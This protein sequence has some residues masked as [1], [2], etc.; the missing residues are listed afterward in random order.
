VTEEPTK[1]SIQAEF[2]GWYVSRGSDDRWHAR[3][4]GRASGHGR[5]R[6]PRRPARGDHPQ[7]AKLDEQAWL[8]QQ[9]RGQR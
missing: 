5:R 8:A 4:R 2:P 3:L 1:E 7:I 6:P 9:N